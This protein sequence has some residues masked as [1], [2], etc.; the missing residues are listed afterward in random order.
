MVPVRFRL[1]RLGQ[2]LHAARP[3]RLAGDEGRHASEAKPDSA[4]RR[5]ASALAADMAGKRRRR[6]PASIKSR[7]TAASGATGSGRTPAAARAPVAL[8]KPV[9]AGVDVIAHRAAEHGASQSI[10]GRKPL[11]TQ[12]LSGEGSA[13]RRKRPECA[14]TL[15]RTFARCLLLRI[16]RRQDDRSASACARRLRAAAGRWVLRLLVAPPASGAPGS[17][18]CR[19]PWPCGGA[20]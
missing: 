16:K 10:S 19:P 15:L 2:A 4:A 6:R 12:I 14:S 17:G 5:Q 9:D 13:M 20:R 3:H 11:R 8:R 18:R 1:M 7:K